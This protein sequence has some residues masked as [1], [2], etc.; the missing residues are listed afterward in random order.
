MSQ[1][2]MIGN[3]QHATG[4]R[5]AS[6]Q[7][8]LA[9][10]EEAQVTLSLISNSL[11]LKMLNISGVFLLSSVGL[12]GSLSLHLP[13]GCCA[14]DLCILDGEGTEC[15][16]FLDGLGGFGLILAEDHPKFRN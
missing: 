6:F 3:Y 11:F 9:D 2:Y 1:Q 7:G 4:L 13:D 8:G 12:W 10:R 15:L 14:V 16:H 5:R